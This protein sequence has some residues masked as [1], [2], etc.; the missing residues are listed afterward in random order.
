M[1]SYPETM[2][3]GMTVGVSSSPKAIFSTTNTDSPLLHDSQGVAM[4]F[5]PVST[6]NIVLTGTLVVTFPITLLQGLTVSETDAP[7]HQRFSVVSDRIRVTATDIEIT[8]YGL[9]YA[10]AVR[11]ASAWQVGRPVTVVDAVQVAAHI[12]VTFGATILE[13]LRIGSSI[14]VLAKYGLTFADLVSISS[15]LGRMLGGAMA[16]TLRVTGVPLVTYQAI[17]TTQEHAIIGEALGHSL[18]MSVTLAD[19]TN[20]SDAQLLRMIYRGDALLDGVVI[21][22]GYVSPSGEFTTW[23]INTRTNAV[24]EYQNWAFNSFAKV[25]RKYIGAN[26]DGLYELDGVD[27]DGASIPTYIA[28]GLFQLNGSRYTAF[29]AAYLGMRVTTDEQMFLKL[30]DGR[31]NEFVYTV[32]PENMHSTRVNFGKG[33]RSRYFGWALQTV[34]ADYDLESIVFVPLFS[35][36][37][38]G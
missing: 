19:T 3:Q 38:V 14:A 4:K 10:D 34:A 32:Q 30:V 35:Q 29:K 6:D 22:A 27:D 36:R 28:S 2:T 21:T 25:G 23:A 33:L 16:E 15:A 7:V 1:A 37:R 31:G 11:I 13:R 12:I 9:R 17:S 26:G 20:L 5:R 8:I 18:L 24:T